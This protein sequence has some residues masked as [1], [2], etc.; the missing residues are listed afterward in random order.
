MAPTA[1]INARKG[2]FACGIYP[3]S[4]EKL[5]AKIPNDR[6]TSHS[7]GVAEV[8]VDYLREQRNPK[9]RN[10]ATKRRKLNVISGR[11]VAFED[12][13]ESSEADTNVTE[14]SV[15]GEENTIMKV[16]SNIFQGEEHLDPNNLETNF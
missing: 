3:L 11:L 7:A 13:E 1:N 12:N 6:Q 9:K 16:K 15:Q 4:K 8:I 14:E 10:A 5:L 2:F